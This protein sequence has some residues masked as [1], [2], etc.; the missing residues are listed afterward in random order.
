MGHPLLCVCVCVYLCT[1][2]GMCVRVF[3][4]VCMHPPHASVCKV[5][6]IPA[7]SVLSTFSLPQI[8]GIGWLMK[9]PFSRKS[10][11]KGGEEEPL[12]P[13][14]RPP[15]IGSPSGAYWDSV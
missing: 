7:S 6:P 9:S 8:R 3:V 4:Y 15:F 2:A 5:H 13:Y 10:L 11:S 1:H 14:I 12:E